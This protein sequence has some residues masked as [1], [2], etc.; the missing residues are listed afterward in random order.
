MHHTPTRRETAHVPPE[1]SRILN[2][3]QCHPGPALFPSGTHSQG[4][5]FRQLAT[6]L[7]Q[8]RCSTCPDLI[9]QF[10]PTGQRSLN[11]CPLKE[12]NS[13]LILFSGE[14]PAKLL[15]V[16]A[17]ASMFCRRGSQCSCKS[18]PLLCSCVAS[19]IKK[20]DSGNL[21]VNHLAT[22]LLFP[23]LSVAAEHWKA[24]VSGTP[25]RTTATSVAASSNEAIW[26]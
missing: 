2:G 24:L 5:L 23:L 14:K 16:R 19:S 13:N 3:C 22:T 17:S 12:P 9:I 7:V 10:Y 1:G 6:W 20:A 4:I 15:F 8:L 11:M 26:R 21:V 18:A 25:N